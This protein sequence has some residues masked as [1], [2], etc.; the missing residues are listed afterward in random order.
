LTKKKHLY[1]KSAT[2]V[3]TRKLLF[4]EIDTASSPVSMPPGGRAK[5]RG[6]SNPG[7]RWAPHATSREL[8][9]ASLQAA[10]A[11][12]PIPNPAPCVH[13]P[14]HSR[15]PAGQR[16]PRSSSFPRTAEQGVR[17]PEGRGGGCGGVLAPPRERRLPA[18]PALLPLPAGHLLRVGGEE[19]FPTGALVPAARGS[20]LGDGAWLLC[21][22]ADG[23]RA[24]LPSISRRRKLEANHA[25]SHRHHEVLDFDLLPKS[26]SKVQPPCGAAAP[27]R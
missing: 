9:A 20:W 15:R 1:N 11:G 14:P 12:E 10:D 13:V 4:N 19:F 21:I 8:L 23:E 26:S 18:Y 22:S 27:R 17:R 5:R 2:I 25:G 7:H 6:I 16:P 24:E 3:H